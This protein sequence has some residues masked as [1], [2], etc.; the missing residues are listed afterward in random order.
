[1]VSIQKGAILSSIHPNDAND[2]QQAVLAA[3]TQREEWK[4]AFQ[5]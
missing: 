1:M 4:R 5:H 3:S 2:S